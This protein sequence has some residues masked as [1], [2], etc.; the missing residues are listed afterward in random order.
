MKPRSFEAI[1]LE[2]IENNEIK[3]ELP[4]IGRPEEKGTRN[5]SI[6]KSCN[7]KYS[8]KELQTRSLVETIF[9]SGIAEVD[10]ANKRQTDLMNNIIDFNSSTKPKSKADK[11]KK[12]DTLESVNNLYRGQELV[13]N[14]FKSGIF[15][16]PSKDKGLTPKILT[17]K[18]THQRLP[19][20]LAQVKAGNTSGNLLN[21]IRQIVYSL[22]RSKE[23]T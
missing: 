20:A 13:L 7:G 4:K 17:P 10:K 22:Y 1:F 16:K 14:A 2:D 15:P 6:Y 12:N 8:F 19:I 3:N 5:N 21:K 11:K 9:S 18:Q 23:I